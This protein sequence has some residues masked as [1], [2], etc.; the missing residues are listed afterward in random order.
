MA[1]D[2]HSGTQHPAESSFP[3][4]DPKTYPSTIFWLLVTFG[5]L[6]MA[7]YRYALPR[8][9][10]ILKT[11]SARIHADLAA[12]NKMRDEARQAAAAYDKTLQDA[13]VRSQQ[14][15]A[16]T[17]NTVKL[18]QDNRRQALE[19]DLTSKLVAAEQRIAEM[20]SNVMAN[21]GQIANEAAS[22]IVQHITG[23]PADPAAVA[24]AVAEAGA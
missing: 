23:K 7:L 9:E 2:L 17:R 11:R 19:A 14:L 8:V 1:S 21:V 3:P 4:F 13:R 5:V 12:A 6:Y 16:E 10:S 18:E 22:A 15:A 20:K 24:E